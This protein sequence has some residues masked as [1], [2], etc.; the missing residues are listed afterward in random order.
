M[1]F[2]FICKNSSH[3]IRLQSVLRETNMD[4]YQEC[5]LSSSLSIRLH[6]KTNAMK[7][8]NI[9]YK[10]QSKWGYNKSKVMS[11][12]A[13]SAGAA[14]E[15]CCQLSDIIIYVQKC[16]CWCW[17]EPHD[18]IQRTVSSQRGNHRCHLKVR[19]LRSFFISLFALFHYLLSI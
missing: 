2:K 5:S 7:H 13:I 1:M 3:P 4:H 12:C 18:W 14:S 19:G 15:N 16:Q 6:F 8:E 11:H 17:D 10:R 9:I